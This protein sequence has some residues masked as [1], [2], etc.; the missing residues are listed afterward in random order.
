VADDPTSADD[1]AAAAGRSVPD[2]DVTAMLAQ[3]AMESAAPL[4][5]FARHLDSPGRRIAL[6]V[7]GSVVATIVVFLLMALVG[8]LL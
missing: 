3:L 8:V 2:A 6:M 1:A 7:G 4:G 5:R